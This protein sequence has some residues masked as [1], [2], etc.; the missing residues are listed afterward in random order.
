MLS[1]VMISKSATR[2]GPA[3]QAAKVPAKAR[4]ATDD[5]RQEGHVVHASDT[6]RMPVNAQ[7]AE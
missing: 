1:K 7:P 6:V 3:L 4:P 2:K 5:G